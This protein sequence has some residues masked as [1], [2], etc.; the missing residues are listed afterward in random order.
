[1]HVVFGLLLNTL[2]L[3]IVTTPLAGRLMEYARLAKHRDRVC[4]LYALLGLSISAYFLY[5]LYQVVASRSVVVI[6]FLERYSPPLGACFEIDMLSVFMASLIIGLG[7]TACLYSIRYMEHDTGLVLYYVLLQGLVAGM[8][9][10]VFAGDLFTLFV[11]WELMCLASYCLVAYRKERWAPVEAGFKF[12]VMSSFGNVT[13]LFAM[14]LLYGITGTLNLAFL[15]SSLK[16]ATS[17]VWILLAMLMVVIGFGVEAALVPLHFWLPD[18]HPEAPS[19]VSAL[20][21]G[22]VI[23]TGGYA[24]LRILFLVFPSVQMSWQLILAV[25]AV[26]TMTVG[27][28]MALLQEDLKRLLAYSSVAQMGYVIFG[29]TSLYGVTASLFHVMNHAI[30]KGLLFFCAGCYVHMTG[31]R[32]INELSG[33]WKKMPLTTAAFA[34]GAFSI[35]G[36]PPFNGFLSELMLITAGIKAGT[37]PAQSYMTVFA[38]IMILNVLFSVAYYLRLVQ[39][40]VL[41]KESSKVGKAREAPFSMLVPISLLAFLCFLI[42]IYPYP[43][44]SFAES[45]ANAV[46]QASSYIS[47]ITG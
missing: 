21:S 15:A 4:G 30:M 28:L 2:L 33:V 10:V 6:T 8:V 39:T 14:S 45:A 31:T 35:A 43:F 46:V 44:L 47:A 16:N 12:L 22:V 23:K 25:A 34:I 26:V 41:K 38:A 27:N 32:D 5:D 19:P 1:M 29:L 20:L 18:A 7:V 3:F 36:M 42:G 17:S 13:V 37:Q 9:G 40:F 24:L 11:F